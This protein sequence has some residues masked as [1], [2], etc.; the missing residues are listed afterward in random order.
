MENKLLLFI[1]YVYVIAVDSVPEKF[2]KDPMLDHYRRL[3]SEKQK[4][5]KIHERPLWERATGFLKLKYDMA[6]RR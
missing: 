1:L 6:V 4:E 3:L 5:Q 2:A